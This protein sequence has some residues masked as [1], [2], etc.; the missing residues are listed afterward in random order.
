MDTDTIRRILNI[1]FMVLA[2]ASVIT[3]FVVEDFTTFIYVC[4][5]AIFVKLCEFFLRFML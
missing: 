2:V 4:S 3:Y 5:A 1:V